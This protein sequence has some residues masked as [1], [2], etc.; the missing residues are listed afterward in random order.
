LIE[1]CSPGG[2]KAAFSVRISLDEY[3]SFALKRQVA[4]RQ[5][6]S[7]RP[8]AGSGAA[9][10]AP[11]DFGQSFRRHGD[12]MSKQRNRSEFLDD[13]TSRINYNRISSKSAPGARTSL[14]TRISLPGGENRQSSRSL[15][16]N[17]ANTI[18][19]LLDELPNDYSQLRETIAGWSLA[20]RSRLAARLEP[21]FNAYIQHIPHQTLEQKQAW[22]KLANYEPDRL[23]LSIRCPETGRA[24]L[25]VASTGPYCKE[26]RLFLEVLTEDG[27]RRRRVMSATLPYL[28]LMAND[29]TR[30][31]AVDWFSRVSGRS[32]RTDRCR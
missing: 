1:I 21:T 31:M 13:K 7:Y 9:I 30:A 19:E 28:E 12:A 3:S 27:H 29:G 23:G 5:V 16:T 24:A 18:S 14:G 32:N 20:F 22:A 4:A 10:L 26:G 11:M 6:P 8:I 25:V 2:L 15:P 17:L